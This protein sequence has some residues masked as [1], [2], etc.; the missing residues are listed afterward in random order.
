MK[1]EIKVITYNVDGLPE[2][3]DLSSLPWKL[4]PIAWIYKIF[5]GTTLVKV[6][7][8]RNG[9]LNA[10]NISKYFCKS[11]ADIIGVQEDFNY[12]HL[13]VKYLRNYYEGTFSGEID[14]SK[15]KDLVKWFPIPRIKLDGLNIFIKNNICICNEFIQKWNKSHGYFSHANDKLLTKGFRYY[16]LDLEYGDRIN[17]YLIHMDADFYAIGCPNVTKDVEARKSQ[18]EQLIYNIKCNILS[19]NWNPTIIMGDT[20]SYNQYDWDQRNIEYFLKE[21]NNISGINAI[22][23]IPNNYKDCDRIFLLNF[24]YSDYKLNLKECYYDTEINFSDH[25]PLVATFEIIQDSLVG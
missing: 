3:I 16:D 24:D 17:V 22:E 15:I 6:N 14:L 20:N 7:D 2:F 18:F 23:C 13:L 11:N 19:G 4:K 12:N 10:T 5:K 8:N 25:Y 1:E 9:M 21:L